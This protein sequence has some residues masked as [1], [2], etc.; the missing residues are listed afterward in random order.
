MGLH[1]HDIF[2]FDFAQVGT[3]PCY[4]FVFFPNNVFSASTA[5]RG[6]WFTIFAQMIGDE[7]IAISDQRTDIYWIFAKDLPPY[8]SPHAFMRSIILVG[9]V[10]RAS[11]HHFRNEVKA[12]L[13]ASEPAEMGEWRIAYPS[14]TCVTNFLSF[15][16]SIVISVPSADNPNPKHARLALGSIVKSIRSGEFVTAIKQG[17]I[18]NLAQNLMISSGLPVLRCQRAI[19]FDMPEWTVDRINEFARDA[20]R[21]LYDVRIIKSVISERYGQ[22]DRNLVMIRAGLLQTQFSVE[23]RIEHIA[24]ELA[25]HVAIPRREIL[26]YQALVGALLLREIKALKD[27]L[28]QL[29][30]SKEIQLVF[31]ELKELKKL[32]T[33]QRKDKVVLK[34]EFATGLQIVGSGIKG[35]L[36]ASVDITDKF[37]NIQELLERWVSLD[38]LIHRAKKSNTLK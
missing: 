32:L 19:I 21:G 8:I 7:G 29:P 15:P 27:Q 36:E 35:A 20:S 37:D 1:V 24:N 17:A 5:N 23:E 3:A 34:A 33:S 16:E 11:A 4:V 28:K 22:I 6:R 25:E 26:T 30:Q 9:F 14:A 13:S 38:K 18:D 10:S 12:I 31:R 2:R